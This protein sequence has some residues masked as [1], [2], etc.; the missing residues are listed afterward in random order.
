M[1]VFS[2][3][4][5]RFEAKGGWS[6]VVVSKST[7]E[8]INPGCKKSYRVKGQLDAHKVKYL[9]LLPAGNGKFIIPMNASI[10]KGTGKTAGDTLRVQL[11][12]DDRPVML[13]R[14]LVDCLKDDGTAYDFFKKLPKGH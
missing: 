9:A 4:I 1:V 3:K 7:S 8:K 13:S 6:Y 11:E 2:A 10:R 14:D 12:L 5:L